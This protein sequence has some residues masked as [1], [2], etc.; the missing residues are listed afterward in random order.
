MNQP[1]NS[2]RPARITRSADAERKRPQTQLPG[3][4][5]WCFRTF[6]PGMPWIMSSDPRNTGNAAR[7]EPEVVWHGMR[8]L[9]MDVEPIGAGP[10]PYRMSSAQR[11]VVWQAIRAAPFR[12]KRIVFRPYLRSSAGASISAFLRAWNGATGA[13]EISPDRNDPAKTPTIVWGGSWGTPY[14]ALEV[15]MDA[16][17]IYY[18]IVQSGS[19]PVWIDQVELDTGPVPGT[20][21][22][23]S[24]SNISRYIEG[25]P[26]L[27][28]EPNWVWK[29]PQN[30]DFEIVYPEEN[31]D[32]PEDTP[33]LP[34]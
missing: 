11:N 34:C 16:E 33:P 21:G 29:E 4:P 26:P 30:L 6:Y 22:A 5:Y 18:G 32:P 7:S 10:K 24:Y 14:L 17:I 27:P 20:P 12:G 28:I 15:P 8:S 1:W 25:L 2:A 3:P 9:R 19:L 31:D 13:P 23:S